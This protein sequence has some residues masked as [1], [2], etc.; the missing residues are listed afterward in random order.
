LVLALGAGVWAL[1]QG[2]RQSAAPL[3]EQAAASA[4]HTKTEG[5]PLPAGAVARLGSVRWRPGAR[6]THLAFSPDG[7]RLASLGNFLHHHDR[8]SIWDTATGRE[9]KT[10][11]IA[12]N[13]AP[14]LN[15]RPDGRG[16]LVLKQ[17]DRHEQL[18]ALQVSGL[19]VWEFTDEQAHPPPP[20]RN[21]P[22]ALNRVTGVDPKHPDVFDCCAIS[23]DGK[24][25]AAYHGHFT[26]GSRDDFAVELWELK[27]ANSVKE[28]KRIRSLPCAPEGCNG[29]V[30]TPDGR[31][32]LAFSPLEGSKVEERLT[33]W[34]V[35]KGQS[36]RAFPVPIPLLQGERGSIAVSSDGR[37]LALG[38]ENGT[39]RLFDLDSGRARLTVDEAPKTGYASVA[40]V[41]FTRDGK[42]LVVGR[43]DNIVKVWDTANGRQRFDLR[44]HQWP[45]A[46]A[47]S[48]DGKL[49]ATSGQDSLILL[50]DAETGKAVRP[51]QGHTYSVFGVAIAPDGRSVATTGWDGTLRL[52]DLDS[53]GQKHVIQ[54][55]RHSP[56][57]SPDGR[58]VL[59]TVGTHLQLWDA[60]LRMWD[61]ATGAE[62]A[63]PGGLAETG[64]TPFEFTPDGRTLLTARGRV[65]AL[66]DW[67]AGR[68]RRQFTAKSNDVTS[69]VLSPDGRT[70]VA[71]SCNYSEPK[72]DQTVEA[73]DTA[74]G[75]QRGR[76]ALQPGHYY[77]VITIAPDS[78]TALI[79]GSLA[80]NEG[81]RVHAWDLDRP[82][83]LRTFESSDTG[84]SVHYIQATAL[85]PDGRT[86][87]TAESDGTT[88]LF[89]VATGRVRRR[90]LGHRDYVTS[91]AFT[92][93][94]KRLITGSADHS[95]LVWDVSLT[96]AAPRNADKELSAEEREKL[97]A[98]LA[99]ENAP[100]VYQA[101]ARLAAVPEAAVALFKSKMRPAAGPD[102][103]TLDRLLRDLDSEQFEVRE[104]ASAE[105]NRLGESAAG[106]VRER[107][108]A[109]K[110]LELRLRL[111]RF[112]EAVD[113]DKPTP[114]RMRRWRAVE[115]LEYLG[116]DSARTLLRE[117]AKGSP[118]APQTQEARAALARLERRGP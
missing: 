114:E 67:P 29:L 53:G 47:V 69:A 43:R 19:R 11:L 117:L 70:L 13:V 10:W 37:T 113:L 101:Q 96:A 93:D 4:A 110:S 58:A 25:L 73:W 109:A 104:K 30:F 32:L 31:T 39:T 112:L 8:L 15:W 40:S 76:L 89:E 38:L 6:T 108:P 5:D 116:T 2:E 71:S 91:L 48:A 41:A 34:D 35:T 66:W 92:P 7:K 107:F 79:L 16:F 56:L 74:T 45:E 12:E 118:T 22:Q 84:R 68:L 60:P 9:L 83:H 20:P 103:A 55:P 85:S 18:D 94:G 17:Y 78:R 88:A 99:G 63:L 65:V 105:L 57:F 49:L 36:R 26:D 81:Q 28:L 14:V 62:R 33:V 102:N 64:G 46:I 90:L 97:W 72:W 54:G 1:P 27:A 75:R 82:D 61:T 50:W 106:G 24:L 59:A 87:A 21:T 115:V 3:P 52:W 86:L 77:Q 23:P 51:P 42:G 95:C 100:A 111:A 98:D 44:G 80:G